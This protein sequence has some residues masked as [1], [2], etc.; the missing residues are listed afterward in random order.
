MNVLLRKL[1]SAAWLAG[2]SVRRAVS[3]SRN[4]SRKQSRHYGKR[5]QWQWKAVRERMKNGRVIVVNLARAGARRILTIHKPFVRASRRT[6]RNLQLVALRR[7]EWHVER[8]VRRLARSRRP[9]VLGPWLSEVGYEALYW[10]PFLTWLKN[11]EGWDPQRV[12]A[13]SRGGV[14]SWYAGLAGTYVETFDHL[15]P[16]AF[17]ARN[18][19]RREAAEG[20]HKQLQLSELDRELITFACARTGLSDPVVIHPSLMY[21]LFR[22]FWLGHRP[23]SHIEERT[24][25]ARR[26][27]PTAFD[28][29][30]L[31]REYV[32][33]KAYT[34]QSLPDTPRTRQLLV[35]LVSHLAESSHVVTLDTGFAVDDHGD[36]VFERHPRVSTLAGLMTPQ[37]NLELQTQV[38]AHAQAFVGTCGGLAWLA[39]LLGV[40]TVALM[41]D[42]RFLKAHLHV[43]RQV[44]SAVGAANFATVDLNAVDHLHLDRSTTMPLAVSSEGM[45]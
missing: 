2:H 5:L 16:Q 31:P 37:N 6:E 23:L 9:I 13:I 3:R 21:R 27:P 29:S 38:I 4:V 18:E 22:H 19:A 41:S 24:R 36:Y 44:Y 20:S 34:A 33:V 14:A 10:V 42:P 35:R 8:E 1:R 43:A 12:V 11:E 40:P 32:A 28:L 15:S 26:Q 45:R 17:A 7:E 30:G 39:P 25:F